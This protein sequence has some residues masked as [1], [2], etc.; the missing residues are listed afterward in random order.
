[1]IRN[2]GW[3]DLGGLVNGSRLEILPKSEEAREIPHSPHLHLEHLEL[4]L[5]V[6]ALHSRS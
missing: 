3:A 6:F 5:V 1:M 4:V 2:S